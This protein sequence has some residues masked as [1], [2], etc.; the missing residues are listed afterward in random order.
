MTKNEAIKVAIRIRPPSLLESK[1]GDNIALE[2]HENTLTLT[3]PSE[4]KSNLKCTYDAVLGMS[5]GQV[6]VFETVRH[7]VEGVCVGVN[8]CV[9]SYGQ[10][11]AGKTHTMV[12]EGEKFDGVIPLS[13]RL[14]FD[15]MKQEQL[16]EMSGPETNSDDQKASRYSVHCSFLQIYNEKLYDL[17]A[18]GGGN[19]NIRETKANNRSRSS[20]PEVFVSGLSEF[21]VTS[22]EDVMTLIEAGTRTRA[23][24]STEMNDVSS[25]SHAVLQLS[26]ESEKVGDDYSVI[27]RAKLSLV[28]LAGSEKMNTSTK[29]KKDHTNEL[30]CINSSL[31]ALGNVMSALSDKKR[32]HIPY[33]DSKLTRLLQD[34]LGGKLLE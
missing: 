16:K 25:R 27:R 4:T 5:S 12:G 1:R 24:R 11:G 31:S 15:E 14:L 26:V 28:D 22:A 10:T 6:D 2:A 18:E 19:L 32:H 34:S 30:T 20:K 29:M 13:I 3:T 17:L 23:L 33:R 9:F 7:C 21:R 8:G